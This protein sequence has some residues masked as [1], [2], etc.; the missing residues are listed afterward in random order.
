MIPGFV[1]ELTG[2]VPN[3]EQTDEALFGI[4]TLNSTLPIVLLSVFILVMSCYPLDR[5]T[6][7]KIVEE[8]NQR[9]ALA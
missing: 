9:E 3:V 1:L 5:K 7:A 4:L 2:Y 6:H 8:L